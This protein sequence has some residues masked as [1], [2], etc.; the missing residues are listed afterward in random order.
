MA[1]QTPKRR[2]NLTID[3]HANFLM[4]KAHLS[5]KSKTAR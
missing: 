2:Q 1:E 4:L 3:S 5:R